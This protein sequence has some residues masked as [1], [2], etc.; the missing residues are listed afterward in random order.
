MNAV[1]VPFLDDATLK[2]IKDCGGLVVIHQDALITVWSKIAPTLRS[3]GYLA[4]EFCLHFSNSS[5]I[6]HLEALSTASEILAQ[7]VRTFGTHAEIGRFITAE[8]V[9]RIEFSP[10]CKRWF[11]RGTVYPIGFQI[12]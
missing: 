6:L 11:E 5:S 10:D 3:R 1:Q 2:A 7:A 4:E 12:A 9:N 8:K